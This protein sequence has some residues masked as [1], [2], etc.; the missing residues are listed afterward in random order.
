VTEAARET[1]TGRPELGRDDPPAPWSRKIQ[2]DGKR[3][4]DREAK[5][6]QR[7]RSDNAPAAMFYDDTPAS[8]RLRSG[9]V[10]HRPPKRPEP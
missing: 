9:L 1:P 6:R 7:L 10:D 8:G 2:S 4:Y 3:A 5:R